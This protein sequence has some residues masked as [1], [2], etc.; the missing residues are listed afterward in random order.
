[1]REDNVATAMLQRGDI[2]MVNNWDVMHN[3]EAFSDYEDPALKRRLMRLWVNIPNVRPL[4]WEIAD[5]YNTGHREG[6]DVRESD[7][8]A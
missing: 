4:P 2:I 7:Q 8:A 3:R 1:M 5:H 6:T